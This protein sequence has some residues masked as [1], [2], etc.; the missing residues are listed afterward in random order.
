MEGTIMTVGF[1]DVSDIPLL[2]HQFQYR[3]HMPE[4]YE[5]SGTLEDGRM[6]YFLRSYSMLDAK[7]EIMKG[8]LK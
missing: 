8:W 6:D 5:L 7:I 3:Q 4:T 2:F 1:T